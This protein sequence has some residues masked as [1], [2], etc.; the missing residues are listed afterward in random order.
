MYI[1]IFI[2]PHPRISTHS[3]I[4]YGEGEKWHEGRGD[5]VVLGECDTVALY[6]AVMSLADFV[7]LGKVGEGA[8]SSV[9]KV[10]RLSDGLVYALKKVGMGLVRCG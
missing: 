7:V 2:N 1:I 9:F 4:I 3:A 10:R 8:Y 6:K 5:K